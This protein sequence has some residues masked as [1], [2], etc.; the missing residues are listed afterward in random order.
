M[1]IT[2][3]TA[4]STTNPTLVFSAGGNIMKGVYINAARAVGERERG[5][6]CWTAIVLVFMRFSF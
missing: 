1:V 3:A 2:P 4:P 6:R 5:V